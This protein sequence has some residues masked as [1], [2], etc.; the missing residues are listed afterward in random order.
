MT[1]RV[2]QELRNGMK[3]IQGRSGLRGF[4]PF[5]EAKDGTK[6]RLVREGQ[7]YVMYREDPSEPP[8]PIPVQTMPEADRWM[9]VFGSE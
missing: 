9:Q 3:M 5:L 1:K 4:P 7:R 2:V 6:L 8:P